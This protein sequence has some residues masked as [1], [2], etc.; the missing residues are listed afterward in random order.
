M[1]VLY[2]ILAFVFLL[3]I[4]V[5]VHEWGH[6]IAA[7]LMGVRVEVFSFGFGKRLWGKQMG[8]TD[9]RVSLIP[10]GGYVKMAGEE[11]WDPDDLKP[12][13]FQAKNRG[14]K[15]F[16]LIMGP[17]MNLLL[18]FIILTIINITG[19]KTQAYKTEVPRIGYVI[20]GSAAEAVDIRKDDLVL[21]INGKP[22]PNW[23][24]L[25]TAVVTNPNEKLQI[26]IERAGQVLKK[27]LDIKANKEIHIG[28]AGL[29][30]GFS[31]RIESFSEG[32][33]AANAGL[34][35]GDIIL[36]INGNPVTY[37][38]LNDQVGKSEGKSLTIKV[39]RNEEEPE[40]DVV[41]KKNFRLESPPLETEKEARE[42]LENVRKA[43]PDL[44]FDSFPEQGKYKIFSKIFDTGEEAQT[45][46]KPALQLPLTVGTQWVIGITR[47]PYSGIIEKNYG[48]FPAMGK[49][50][51]DLIR[52]TGLVFTA[53][54][55][56]IVGKLSPKNL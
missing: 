41:P 14:Q 47:R 19:V 2:S 13:E 34:E 4:I 50:V 38:D 6:Y 17:L 39:R 23:D 7:R 10:L 31:S 56:M 26:E 36:A 33:P 32:S 51:N 21:S 18:A 54:K 20:K 44:E 11:E 30:W 37:F 49:S 45:Y 15:M 55:K 1:S 12:D 35:I 28:E 40:F 43:L 22:V 53:I 29:H 27:E 48:V 46:L 5:V 25:D 42:M 8:D 3:G 52:I 16:I 9:F 24:Y